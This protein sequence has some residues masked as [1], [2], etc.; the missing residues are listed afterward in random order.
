MPQLWRQHDDYTHMRQFA[1]N[2]D[3]PQSL[4]SLISVAKRVEKAAQPEATIRAYGNDANNFAIYVDCTKLPSLKIDDPDIIRAFA[5]WGVERGNKLS[6]VKRWFSGVRDM[7]KREGWTFPLSWRDEKRFFQQLRGELARSKD[8]AKL[9]EVKIKHAFSDE[10]IFAALASCDL[11]TLQGMEEHAIL[12]NGIA[13]MLRRSE[14]CAFRIQD[15]RRDPRGHI[16]SLP[17]SK[18][19]QYGPPQHVP[20]LLGSDPATCPV[21]SLDRYVAALEAHGV[22]EGALYRPIDYRDRPIDRG[23]SAST[24]ARI[25]KRLLLRAGVPEDELDLYGA[26]SMRRTGIC[27]RIK[28]GLSPETVMLLARIARR[29]TLEQY[30]EDPFYWLRFQ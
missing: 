26:H 2:L 25:V 18:T 16:M 1:H 10:L 11:S 21:R 4:D 9:V 5:M 13:G 12:S 7:Y 27:K 23:I 3:L 28:E 17:R 24:V 14:F 20:I 6:S 8:N 30:V 15:R 19:N 29:S 22:T